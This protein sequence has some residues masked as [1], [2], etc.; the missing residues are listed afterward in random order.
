MEKKRNNL[1][2]PVFT[3]VEPK[4]VPNP[5]IPK[6]HGGIAPG[7][8]IGNEVDHSETILLCENCDK[9]LWRIFPLV[10]LGPFS[11]YQKPSEAIGHDKKIPDRVG[12]GAN[13]YACP[14]CKKP[15]AKYN[16]KTEGF[17]YKTSKG[18]V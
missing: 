3:P 5:I 14:F 8:I 1:N 6:V 18:Y 4:P 11:S 10:V 2:L 17:R 7:H 16:E 12:L 9:P 15:F 13:R